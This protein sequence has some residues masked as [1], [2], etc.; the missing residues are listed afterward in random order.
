MALKIECHLHR[1]VKGPQCAH[2]C[3]GII[4]M[5]GTVGIFVLDEQYESMRIV[6]LQRLDR[7]SGHFS[8]ARFLRRVTIQFE[9]QILV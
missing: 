6:A 9:I 4:Q 1:L 7:C 8:R 2:Q 3:S 5:T